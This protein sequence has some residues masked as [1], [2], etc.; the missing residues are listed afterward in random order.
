MR[1]MLLAPPGHDARALAEAI[2]AAA[3]LPLLDRVPEPGGGAWA[4]DGFVLGSTPLEPA[5]AEALDAALQALAAPLDLVLLLDLPQ[6]DLTARPSDPDA[7][8]RAV[9]EHYRAPGL[10]RRLR[11]EADLEDQVRAALRIVRDLEGARA[12]QRE[13][14]FAVARVGVAAVTPA[15][16]VSPQDAPTQVPLPT[17]GWKATAAEKGRL[18]R[19]PAG[20]RRGGGSRKPRP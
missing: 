12:P 15:P 4:R 10:L 20:R 1:L 9:A 19:R 7:G 5:A 8:H 6:E 14:P 16:P 18:R 13:E 11:G 3:G 2:A 17:S